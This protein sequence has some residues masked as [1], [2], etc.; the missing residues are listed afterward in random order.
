MSIN[1]KKIK[2]LKLLHELRIRV[3]KKAP[4][5]LKNKFSSADEYGKA[6]KAKI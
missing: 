1:V 5:Q 2:P 6:S 4:K 3:N